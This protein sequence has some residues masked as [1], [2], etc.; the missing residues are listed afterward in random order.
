MFQKS[1][2]IG[3]YY[4]TLLY[5]DLFYWKHTRKVYEDDALKVA[6]AQLSRYALQVQVQ[7]R[8]SERIVE[9]LE[10]KK[11]ISTVPAPFCA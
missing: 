10:S 3:S 5:H 2:I 6:V 9:R 4:G 7:R 1:K 8:Q 11:A